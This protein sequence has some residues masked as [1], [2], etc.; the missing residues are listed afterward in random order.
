MHDPRVN[1]NNVRSVDKTSFVCRLSF[2]CSI[3]DATIHRH[4]HGHGSSSS[5]SSSTTQFSIASVSLVIYFILFLPL[6]FVFLIDCEHEMERPIA[7]R[8]GYSHFS[9]LCVSIQL[10]TECTGEGK[11]RRPADILLVSLRWMRIPCRFSEGAFKNVIESYRW[12]RGIRRRA[13]DSYKWA[14]NIKALAH[15][16]ALSQLSADRRRTQ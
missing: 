6:G 12:E 2:I 9:Q 1:V 7:N 10:T 4:R 11:R 8:T 3:I 14:F 15:G 5:G 13:W 16:T